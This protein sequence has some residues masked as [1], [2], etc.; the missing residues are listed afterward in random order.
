LRFQRLLLASAGLMV[1]AVA[2][3]SGPTRAGAAASAG[4]LA[5]ANGGSGGGVASADDRFV[6][7]TSDASN[8]VPVDTAGISDVFVRDRLT[9]KTKLVSVSSSGTQGNEASYAEGISADGRFVLFESGASNLVP[10]DNNRHNDIFVHDRL[11]GK[12]QR[13]NVSSA[14]KQAKGRYSYEAM[15]GADGRFV[16][17][18]SGASNLVPGDTNGDFDAFVRNRLTGKTERV[19]VGSGDIQANGDSFV[20]AFSVDGR[21]AVFISFASNLVPGV[22]YGQ[23]VYVRDRLNGTTE[24]VSGSRNGTQAN[25][26]SSIFGAGISADGRFVAFASDASNLVAG[27]TNRQ[28]DVFVRDR[29]SV[30]T[31]LASV[32]SNGTQGNGGSGKYGVGISADGRYVVFQSDASNLVPDDTNGHT[33]IFVRDRLTGTTKR[34]SVSSSGMQGDGNSSSPTISADG[35]LVLFSSQASNLVPGET[36]DHVSNLFVHDMV[37][38]TTTLVSSGL[39]T[40]LSAGPGHF[41]RLPWPPRAG[42]TLRA[43]LPIRVGKAQVTQARVFCPARLAGYKLAPSLRRFTDSKAECAWQI[44]ANAAG[45]RLRA[46]IAAWKRDHG[47]FSRKFTGRVAH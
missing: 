16:L 13:V 45:K 41:Q 35:R 27:D 23:D 14:G 17:F 28:E 20:T 10:G 34:V 5:P 47:T 36:D 3:V 1:F 32:S 37:T 7:F 21:F 40:K 46:S 38:G 44:P 24:L 42:Q 11:T 15:I 30:T 33:D 39:A 31:E 4:V 18:D 12:T 29:L 2:V 43:T 19:S 22:T 9:G 25:G 8:L 6:A 26:G